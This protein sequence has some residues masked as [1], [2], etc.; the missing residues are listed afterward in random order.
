M[1]DRYN[2]RYRA[3]SRPQPHG[4]VVAPVS[5][6]LLETEPEEI[7]AVTKRYLEDG[8]G[9]VLTLTIVDDKIEENA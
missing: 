5:I 2:T 7:K 9:R 1:S 8:D 6:D 3:V 4:T